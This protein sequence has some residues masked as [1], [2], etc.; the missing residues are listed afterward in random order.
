MLRWF[1][2]DQTERA[3]FDSYWEDAARFVW[4][5]QKDFT[6]NVPPTQG[7]KKNEEIYNDTP[8][9]NAKKYAA[10][11]EAL[12]TRRSTRWHRMAARDE[13]LRRVPR[14]RAY[15]EAVA[16]DLFAVRQAREAGCYSALAQCYRAD[17][18]FGN[19]AL[20]IDERV[21]PVTRQREGIRY[22]AMP[23]RDV[24]VGRGW[25]DEINRAF[26]RYQLEAGELVR[27]FDPARIP[28]RWI[29][30]AQSK[31]TEKA[32]LLTALLPN[33]SYEPRSPF[34]RAW[35][36][37][38]LLLDERTALSEASDAYH[39]LPL[40][41]TS[42][43]R[44]PW[45]TYGRG[46]AMDVLPTIKTLNQIVK[47]ALRA[48]EKMADPPLLV[49]DDGVLGVSRAVRLRSGGITRGGID[50][51]GRPMVQALHTGGSIQGAIE[52][53]E[54]LERKLDRHFLVDLF[55][56]LVERPQMTAAEIL[57]RSSEKG[58][59]VGPI[60]GTHQE[61]KL[62]PMVR[63]EYGLRARQGSLPE[64]PPEL[65]EAGGQYELEYETPAQQLQRAGE[66]AAIEQTL[67]S[68]IPLG[69]VDPRA[70]EIVDLEKTG[71]RIAELRGYPSDLIRSERQVARAIEVRSREAK[72]AEEAAAL[73][74]KAR[75]LKDIAAAEA[76]AA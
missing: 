41:Y 11:L 75:A 12:L 48:A 65:V 70:L 68:L 19:D 14:V 24:W 16:T 32:T 60:I 43:E 76:S 23:I 66:T 61:Q 72:A 71:R 54:Y 62:A 37:T 44:A 3:L 27:K 53:L 51:N 64:M 67:A 31:P 8:T 59:F 42:G 39:E 22:R 49:R 40:I 52:M 25:Q 46:V 21:D 47:D 57:E 10:V 56:L 69:Q 4:P 7:V 1:E 6:G 35:S 2:S 38:E 9:G 18:V 17:G 30:K 29:D 58:M 15:Y 63:R 26:V 13:T 34:S 36:A 33:P 45:E 73:P 74:D 5:N 28:Q 55:T 50:K 20:W